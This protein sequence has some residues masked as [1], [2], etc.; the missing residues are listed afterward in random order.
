MDIEKALKL[1]NAKEL[2]AACHQAEARNVES[3]I[4]SQLYELYYQAVDRENC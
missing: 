2:L 4:V 1:T 3:S